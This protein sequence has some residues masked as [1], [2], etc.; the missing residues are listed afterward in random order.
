MRQLPRNPF[1]REPGEG[2]GPRLDI[3][4]E[5]ARRRAAVV[6]RGSL[7]S[8]SVTTFRSARTRRYAVM[9]VAL[10]IV[11]WAVRFVLAPI[12]RT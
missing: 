1:I 7:E 2:P 8:V 12:P 9:F 5:A 4:T 10:V 11:I 6:G 3:T